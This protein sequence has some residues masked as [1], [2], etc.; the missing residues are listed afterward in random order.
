MKPLLEVISEELLR[1][2]QESGRTR[3]FSEGEE[4]FA[5]G[6]EAD[7]LPVVLAG[8]VKMIHF[9]EAGKEVI[10]GIFQDGEM[11]AVPPI[12]DGAPYP[13]TA[14][15]MEKT[16]I[17]LLYRQDF[18]RLLHESSEFSFAVI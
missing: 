2:M 6:G 4:I 15:A 8:K 16:K 1:N 18:L 9:L 7:F 13:A 3:T 5:Q 14:I 17:L 12:F 11:F 10:I